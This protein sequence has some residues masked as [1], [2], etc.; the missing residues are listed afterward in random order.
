[1]VDTTTWYSTE[2]NDLSTQPAAKL[3]GKAGPQKS[4]I[5]SDWKSQPLQNENGDEYD[6]NTCICIYVYIY[7]YKLGIGTTTPNTLTWPALLYQRSL[8]TPRH[9]H[10]P[11]LHF[12][13]QRV[14][15]VWQTIT[16][17]RTNMGRFSKSTGE[18]NFFHTQYPGI[19]FFERQWI[20]QNLSWNLMKIRWYFEYFACVVSPASCFG[21]VVW[22]PLLALGKSLWMEG[23]S[24]TTT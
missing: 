11:C 22:Y 14:G 4:K 3:A 16:C 21:L 5:I 9:G 10:V 17:Q 20:F 7:I 12:Q 19:F 23:C 13:L 6:M 18:L 1:M 24:K 15:G 2:C 8:L